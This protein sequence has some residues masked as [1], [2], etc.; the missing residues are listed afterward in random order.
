MEFITTIFGT[1]FNGMVEPVKR[2]LGYLC[3][4]RSNVQELRSHVKKLQDQKASVIDRLGEVERNGENIH[5][6]VT[7]WLT[8]T[9]EKIA[10][11]EEFQSNEGH[12]KTGCSYGSF[13][14]LKI[15]HKLGR[16][17]GKMIPQ[18]VDLF[19]QA[20]FVTVSSRPEPEALDVALYDD[21]YE[22]FK[23]RDAIAEQVMKALGDPTI[24]MIGIYGQGGVGKTTLVKAVATKAKA[25]KLF[26]VVVMVNITSTPDIRKI[27]GEIADML[28]LRLDEE[29]E[30]GRAGRLKQRF[31][32]EKENTLVILD[33]LWA[34][35]DLSLLGIQLKDDDQKTIPN[36]PN[37]GYDQLKD[38]KMASDPKKF[39]ILLTSRH[40]E[41]LSSEME[42]KDSIFKV[43]VMEEEE[44]EMLFNKVAGITDE[45]S[46][47]KSI[48]TKIVL[49]C[50]NL[51]LAIEAAG[52]ALKNN[53]N[54]VAW[55]NALQRLEK[56]EMIEVLEPVE[57]STMLSYDHL[58]S[59]ELKSIFLLCARLGKDLSIMYLVKYC[60]GLRI[61]QEVNTMKEVRGRTN[62]S[63]EKL[64]G[65][66]LLLDTN[67]PDCVA[68]H[69]MIRDAALS[70]AYKYNGVFTRRDAELDE[71]PDRETFEK[72]TVIS[73][74]CCDIIDGIPEGINC[75]QLKVFHLDSKD[76]FIKIPDK[77][78]EGM[79]ELRV[80]ILTGIGL[81]SFPS[82][83]KCLI[84]LRML[85]LEKCVLGDNISII[86]ELKTLR[87]LSLLGSK[88]EL[89]P[90]E[91]RQLGR[92][93]L[94]DI[95]SCTKLKVI[96]SNVMSKLNRLEE[97]YMGK[98]LIPWG[99]KRKTNHNEIASL[100]EL[101]SLQQLRNLDIHIEDITTLPSSL[102]FDKLD[103][104][105]IVIGDSKMLLLED[106]QMSC[107][108]K[109]SRV[110]ALHLKKDIDIHLQRWVK[111]LLKNVEQLLL[112][113][114]DG[115]QN[116]TY[117]LDV[118]G[119]QSLKHLTIEKNC[120]IK[121]IIY[122]TK[123]EH[124]VKAFPQLES[125]CLYKLESLEKICNC[126][127]GD[128]SFQSLKTMRINICGRL[129][130][131]FS[132][133]MTRLL[134]KLETLEVSE[135]DSLEDLVFAERQEN[136]GNDTEDDRIS[137]PQL[138][139][140]TLQSL[141]KLTWFYANDNMESLP[142]CIPFFNTEVSIR[143]LESLELSSIN[144][145]KV[146]DSQPLPSSSFENLTKLNVNDC[147]GL[148]YLF[149]LPMVGNLMK[150]Q[151]L[152][153]SG[154]DMMEDIFD[155][156]DINIDEASQEVDILPQLKKIEITNMEVLK[157]I[158]HARASKNSFC[159]LKSVIIGDCRKLVTIIPPYMV[160]RF[161]NLG[162]LEVIDCK[163]VEEIF[164]F[165]QP[166]PQLSGENQTSLRVVNLR[167]LPKL[168]HVWN[169]DPQ[170]LLKVTY[171]I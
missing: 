17:A 41:V 10:E 92:L 159:S 156:E 105:K 166:I 21:G 89:L 66:S 67:S 94:L 145:K 36:M 40:I 56:Q 64:K 169:K 161:H 143:K 152:F 13:P 43:D 12:Q 23:S 158:W 93:Q 118:E 45:D 137:F 73:L 120:D 129:K 123:W 24:K 65:S 48:S 30:I 11:I 107:Q 32:K 103:S 29:S 7:N 154:C 16:Q 157:T 162:I 84:K 97:L 34:G 83:I 164:N 149:S 126:Q 33:D 102:D 115:L 124:Q 85:C 171:Q 122:S 128:V 22:P 20:N 9:S 146:W 15:R 98:T 108:Y 91:L 31:K 42:V 57:F 3:N 104:Y 109:A 99:V 4:Y 170:G 39:K 14:N 78:F 68:M 63:I 46:E 79:K 141:S 86:G 167:R 101:E 168:K 150:L 130:Y 25:E 142:G 87:I 153:I 138:R 95:S 69:D 18:C 62:E 127:L 52:K 112:G 131:L 114:V 2:Q 96:P 76:P 82:S 100:A 111:I 132:L 80:L 134:E 77:L 5:D 44:S 72:Y 50:A 140:L 117:E 1:V 147:G 6:V 35:L 74:H 81:S 144:I 38:D 88:F 155:P 55:E 90:S 47:L 151:S 119:F 58:Q 28:G 121:N 113:E 8:K 60:T 37:I 139:Y 116:V 165:C 71:W 51:P 19:Q 106:F 53:K 59:E 61:F 49:K 160:G 133:D 135:C 136:I 163:S 27:Q 110:L 70:I 148:K 26:N 125:M 54:K 75:P